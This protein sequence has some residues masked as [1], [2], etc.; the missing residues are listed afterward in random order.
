MQLKEVVVVLNVFKTFLDHMFEQFGLLGR[1]FQ[2]RR[3]ICGSRQLYWKYH[4]R[5]STGCRFQVQSSCILSDS[6][7][8]I[9]ASYVQFVLGSL[10]CSG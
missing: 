10:I 3:N 7:F 4:T 2:R 6:L 1:Y 5:I 9:L 8:L